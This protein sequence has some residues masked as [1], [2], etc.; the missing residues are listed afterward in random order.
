[1]GVPRRV[2]FRPSASSRPRRAASSPSPA[3]RR[4]P[5]R[6]CDWYR[7][8]GVPLSEIYGMS[9]SSGPMTW[10]PCRIKAGTVGPAIPG[11]EVTLAEDGEVICRG[12]N[13]FVGY[14]ND[15]EKT[16]EALDRR[17]AA[18]RR[19]RRARRRRLPADRRPQEGADH[20]RGRQEHQPRQ[21]RGRAQDDPARR[22]GVRDRRQPAVRLRAGRAR[23]RGRAGV[24]RAARASTDATARRA[25]R[26]PGG[27]SPR[28]S[29]GVAEV[30]G[31][32]QQRRAGQEGA[33]CSARSG[34]PTPRC[35]RRRRS[36]SAAA[37]DAKYAA[38]IESL[39]P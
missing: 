22:P 8:I 19:H 14:L 35:S 27:A 4:S 15:P 30:D 20:H 23:S 5:P 26:E 24:G 25:G 7:A 17:L 34:C 3:R 13:V 38:E 1:M 39:Y 21:P 33:R 18:L 10:A 37:I 11:C 9:E 36:S 2:A 29:A 32:V 16:A 28:S 12:G 6:S 31:A